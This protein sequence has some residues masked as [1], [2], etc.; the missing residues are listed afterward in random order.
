MS[1]RENIAEIRRR[2][3]EAARE[4]G[5]HRRG[6]YTGGRSKMNDAAACQELSPP[7]S[8]CWARTA[9]RRW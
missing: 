7:V 1:I 8:T 9:C 4:T 3:D 6:H 2:I 5:A